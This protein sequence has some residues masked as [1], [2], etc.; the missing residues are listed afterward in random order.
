[1]QTNRLSPLEQTGSILNNVLRINNTKNMKH[2]T[3]QFSIISIVIATVVFFITISTVFAQTATQ[4]RPA[5]TD[6]D[7]IKAE[8]LEGARSTTRTRAFRDETKDEK[9]DDKRPG[10]RARLIDKHEEDRKSDLKSK[11]RDGSIFGNV[12][13]RILER[14]D[15]DAEDNDNNFKKRRVKSLNSQRSDIDGDDTIRENRRKE[16]A[17]GKVGRDEKSKERRLERVSRFLAN[18]NR[19][20][21]SAVSRL[22]KLS[23]R[24][25]SRI[26][27][28]EERG[29]DMT[30]A[31]QLLDTAKNDVKIA[32]ES[33]NTTVERARNAFETNISRD[34]FGGIVSEL[35]KTK[36]VLK[37]AH[38]SLV[39]VIK[40][41]RASLVKDNSDDDQNNEATTDDGTTVEEN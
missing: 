3:L 15:I 23:E 22:E 8:K 39:E 10:V 20:M 18:I 7:R 19:K 34:T 41:M 26:N 17:D 29:L 12:K 30:D 2:P 35:S 11:D 27:K 28:F 13:S 38:R 9:N 5:T 6:I 4:L 1:M 40:I 25:E 21:N 31:K 37:T 32:G 33:I 16:R 24:I 14:R 36:E